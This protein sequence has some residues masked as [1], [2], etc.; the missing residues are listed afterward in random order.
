MMVNINQI[1]AF[2][3]RQT[4]L[5]TKQNRL[6]KNNNFITS[7]RVV[8]KSW[9]MKLGNWKGNWQI[10]TLLWTSWGLILGLK[11]L[12]TLINMWKI[13]MRN[14]K[15]NLMIFLFRGRRWRSRPKI[16]KMNCKVFINKW[17]SDWINWILINVQ[18]IRN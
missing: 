9:I 12:R 18:N 17:N 8:L 7:W 1:R 13:T 16:Y 15:L 3:N 6:V 11:M 5:K 14:L 4:N 2:N 10:I